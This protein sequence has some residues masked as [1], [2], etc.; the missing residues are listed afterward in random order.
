MIRLQCWLL[1]LQE[2]PSRRWKRRGG[3]IVASAYPRTTAHMTVSL[4]SHQLQEARVVDIEARLVAGQMIV[5][6][7]RERKL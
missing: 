4:P 7:K 5:N 3:T 2:G 6:G 1:P